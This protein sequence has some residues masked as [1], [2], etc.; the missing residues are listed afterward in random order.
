LTLLLLATATI[1]T[2]IVAISI[3]QYSK[4]ELTDYIGNA[5]GTN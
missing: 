4:E 1:L 5:S 2:P 3:T